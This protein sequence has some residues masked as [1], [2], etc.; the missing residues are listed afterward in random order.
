MK[1]IEI[2]TRERQGFYDITPQLQALIHDSGVGDGV[3][4]VFCP[5]TTAGLM[6][7]ENWDPDVCHDMGLA[8]DA[9]SPQRADYRHREGNSPAHVKSSL[10]GA[11]QFVF[12]QNGRLALGQWQGVYLA[13]FDGP[14][15]RR[16][17]VKI[18]EA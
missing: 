4:Y 17:W 18:V 13:E 16:V 3:C 11:S 9:I 12:I 2:R 7:N 1:Q 14:R 10:V 15:G 5:H 8:L 6:L